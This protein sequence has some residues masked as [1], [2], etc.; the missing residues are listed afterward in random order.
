MVRIFAAACVMSLATMPAHALTLQCA[1]KTTSMQNTGRFTAE[2]TRN[3]S[4]RSKTTGSIQQSVERDFMVDLE[5]GDNGARLR[6]SREMVPELNNAK[7]GW[8]DV[9]ELSVTER[10]ISGA[11]RVNFAIK[12][13]FEIDRV[14]GVFRSR[15]GME[16]QCNAVDTTRRKF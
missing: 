2:H 15:R 9:Q 13:K 3:F 11:F 14:T 6:I 4:D 12:Q 5:I 1:G 8:F 16:A 10:T 7:N